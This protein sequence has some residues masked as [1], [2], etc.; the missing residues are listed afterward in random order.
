MSLPG[1]SRGF[2]ATTASL[3]S[4]GGRRLE[5][6]HT[7]NETFFSAPERQRSLSGSFS[8][9]AN[10]GQISLSARWRS[11]ETGPGLSR[12]R[13]APEV[14]DATGPGDI[15]RCKRNSSTVQL[16]PSAPTGSPAS[17]S[18]S[19]LPPVET[20]AQINARPQQVVLTIAEEED[21]AGVQQ[22]KEG[23]VPQLVPAPQSIELPVDSAEND[24]IID[25]QPT[26]DTIPTEA[27][28]SD[29]TSALK[30]VASA[31]SEDDGAR[32]ADE[33][34]VPG[35]GEADE[36]DAARLDE[37]VEGGDEEGSGP[38][39]IEGTGQDATEQAAP[40]AT[41]EVVKEAGQDDEPG[42]DKKLGEDDPDEAG[43]KARQDD[44]TGQVDGADENDR[45]GDNVS[46]QRTPLAVRQPEAPQPATDQAEA[47]P[48]PVSG[49]QQAQ[50]GGS[51]ATSQPQ[52]GAA[53]ASSNP[54]AVAAASSN[55]VPNSLAGNLQTRP[56]TSATG[57]LNPN[58]DISRQAKSRTSTAAGSNPSRHASA[59]IRQAQRQVSATAAGSNPA[60][61]APAA[62]RQARDAPAAV[63]QARDAPAAVRQARDAPAAVRQAQR[64][65][66]A[67]AA[68]SNPAPDTGVSAAAIGSNPAPERGVSAAATGSNP[69]PDTSGDEDVTVTPSPAKKRRVMKRRK[70]RKR[71]S[72]YEMSSDSN[73]SPE[74]DDDDD[75]QFPT[76]FSPRNKRGYRY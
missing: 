18:S 69:A 37:G 72:P 40:D 57:A 62:V 70:C 75:H 14:S 20:S 3:P 76:R 64:G 45:D 17:S 24:Y 26:P 60:R 15:A 33:A 36:A 4:D 27:L 73:T 21:V 54:R 58:P 50:T 71:K 47:A 2:E 39:V 53:A 74:E 46:G 63:R 68:G 34:Q 59:V 30:A 13:S 49:L 67:A 25:I 10:P 1:R 51:P 5:T 23:S 7:S 8:A 16:L 32:Q 48:Q 52:R 38:D 42:Q 43:K 11:R 31:A 61:D 19:L 66:S 28:V 56:G 55:P 12:I 44:V 9:S 41:E 29:E 35:Q 6:P 65:V 22:V